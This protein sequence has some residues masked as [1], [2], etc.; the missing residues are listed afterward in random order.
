MVIFTGVIAAVTV[1][2]SYFSYGQWQA[3]NK[4]AQLMSQSIEESKKTREVENR[5]YL[6]ISEIKFDNTLR[7]RKPIEA[8]LFIKN[9][10]KTPARKATATFV[11]AWFFFNPK[12]ATDATIPAGNIRYIQTHVVVPPDS[13]FPLRLTI[14]PVDDATFAQVL[15]TNQMLYIWG[16]LAYED[17]FGNAWK[18]PFCFVSAS[19][20]KTEIIGCEGDSPFK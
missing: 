14:M 10:G 11:K 7:S 8:I 9:T 20:D 17:V 5:A 2:Y 3:T 16:E 13:A 18:E 4:Q 6:N 1:V 15:K 19:L 12:L